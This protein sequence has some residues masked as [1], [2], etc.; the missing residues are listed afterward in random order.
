METFFIRAAQL[1]LSLS[2][3]VVLHEL[4]HF[5]FARLFKVRVEKFYMFFNPNFSIV[6]AKKIN[7]KWVVKFFAPNVPSKFQPKL[8]ANGNEILDAKGKAVYESVD[9]SQ[10]SDDDWRKYPETT[11]WG[12]G[13]VP[14][15]GYCSIAGMVDE[16]KSINELES[17]P[18]EWE[19]RSR[20]VWQRLPIIIGGVLVN[21]LL[22]LVIYSAVLFTWGTDYLPLKNA[23]YGLHFTQ[24]MLDNGFKNGDKILK[25]DGEPV[26]QR[27]E[28]IEKILIDGKQKVTVDRNGQVVDIELPAEFGQKILAAEDKILVIERIPFVFQEVTKDSPAAKAGLMAGDSITGINGKPYFIYQDVVEELEASRNTTISLNYSRAGKAMQSNIQLNETGKLGVMPKAIFADMPLQHTSY[29]FLASI[30]AGINM[31]FETLGSY[32]KQFKLVFTKEGSKQFGGFGSIGKLFPQTW[33]WQ[34]FWSMT[35]FLSIILAFMNL[36]PIPALDGG[37]VLFILYEMIT[38]RKPNDKFLEYA[39]TVGFFL[40]MGLLIYVNGND[41]FR[42]IFK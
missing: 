21:F 9:I 19:Y 1:I 33:D 28:I 11:E 14:F 10:L 39:Q 38:R 7:G 15:G 35:A 12:I 24:L 27:S 31:G 13:W 2:I 6:R 5:G 30:P 32:V 29:G 22:A 8:D 34:I 20:S 41:L 17:E 18:Q 3:L 37:Y 42:A 40:L 26:E 4:G 36:L 25:I 23:K 16:T